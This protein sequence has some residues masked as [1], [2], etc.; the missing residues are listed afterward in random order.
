MTAPSH[1]RNKTATITATT[2]IFTAE[3]KKKYM[4]YQ[5]RITRTRCYYMLYRYHTNQLDKCEWMKRDCSQAHHTTRKLMFPYLFWRNLRDCC[6][7][8][9]FYFRLTIAHSVFLF[10]C[11]NERWQ[12]KIQNSHLNRHFITTLLYTSNG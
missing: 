5:T 6:S 9:L 8:I 10:V 2:L 11:S 1:I 3:V 4:R 12:T 7:W